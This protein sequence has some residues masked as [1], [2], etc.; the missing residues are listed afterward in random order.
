MWR[1]GGSDDAAAREGFAGGAATGAFAGGVA[2]GELVVGGLSLVP[3]S[4]DVAAM[5]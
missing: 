1:A 5:P 4:D 2:T 3:D